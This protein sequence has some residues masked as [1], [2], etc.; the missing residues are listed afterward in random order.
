MKLRLPLPEVLLLRQFAGGAQHFDHGRVGRT[1]V[2]EGGIEIPE[3]AIGGVVECQ[4][5]VGTEHGDADRQLVE[6]AAVRVD[7]MIAR[8]PHGF[9]FGHVDSDAGRAALRRDIEHV[10]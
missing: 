8:R 9:G 1:L 3:R 6:R 5:L 2:E 4:L 10:E 7:E